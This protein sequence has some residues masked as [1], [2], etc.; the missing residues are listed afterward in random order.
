MCGVV[1]VNID[2]TRWCD[3]IVT[4][5]SFDNPQEDELYDMGMIRMYP[6]P[7]TYGAVAK[8]SLCHF[9]AKSG[10]IPFLPAHSI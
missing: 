9:N 10:D 8:F 5:Y 3:Y 2:L 6:F 1:S 7:A 4:Q